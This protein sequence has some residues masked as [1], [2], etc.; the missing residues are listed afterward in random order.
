MERR[1]NIR[2]PIICRIDCETQ[3]QTF[4][5]EGFDMSET[6]VSFS[7]AVELPQNTEVLLHYRMQ[8]DGPMVTARV[9]ICQQSGGRYGAKFL[10]R[11]VAL[12][13]G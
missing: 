2:K 9:L 1:L 8:E 3:H 7:A 12:A 5:A 4:S 10:D 6:G 11:K 13:T